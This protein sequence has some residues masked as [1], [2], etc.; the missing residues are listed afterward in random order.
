MEESSIVY[1]FVVVLLP[2]LISIVTLLYQI[3][4]DGR[5]SQKENM[6]ATN[7]LTEAIT[8]L[9]DEI[10]YMSCDNKKRD[11]R[12]SDHESRIKSLE[13]KCLVVQTDMKHFHENRGRV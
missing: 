4:K 3:F 12:L 6:N 9:R 2:I 8:T 13:S 11:E 5:D 1:V 10:R 7:K